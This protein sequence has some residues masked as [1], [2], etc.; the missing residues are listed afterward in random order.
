MRVDTN[1]TL[2]GIHSAVTLLEM[3]F[4]VLELS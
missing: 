3:M 1:F 4:Q 2:I